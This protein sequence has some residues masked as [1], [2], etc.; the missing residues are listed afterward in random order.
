MKPTL[1][2]LVV[3]AVVN[4]AVLSAEP[5][6][7]L[8][9]TSLTASADLVVAGKI[10]GMADTGRRTVTTEA[11]KQFTWTVFEVSV[12]VDQVLAGSGVPTDLRFEMPFYLTP[13]LAEINAYR[14]LFLSFRGGTY[15]P[16]D[17]RYPW[18]RA[19]PGDASAGGPQ[20]LD[21]V[22]YLAARLVASEQATDD[23]RRRALGATE[24]A[25]SN[26]AIAGLKESF[27]RTPSRSMKLMIAGMLLRLGDLEQLPLVE[28]VLL[29]PER[30]NPGD[31]ANLPSSVRTLTAV[32]AVPTL[33]RLLRSRD[34]RARRAAAEA[35]RF[36][37]SPSGIPG[38]A[39]AL[40]DPDIEVRYAAV[41]GLSEITDTG[42]STTMDRFRS[43]EQKYLQYW[44][45]WALSGG[46]TPR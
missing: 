28:S 29:N 41:S 17:A 38:L 30:E 10:V 40:D 43:S 42:Y 12:A 45:Q 21:K 8:N 7:P 44:R 31:G 34:V 13:S 22:A 9:L 20:P 3:S 4:A 23:E 19:E 6:P 18:I 25:K 27:K 33:T 14:I 26:G 5:I 46:L 1:V 32:E 15:V 36:T 24:L 16:S 2:A 37:G 39:S 11:N 35:L